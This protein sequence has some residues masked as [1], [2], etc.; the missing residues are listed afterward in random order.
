ME[1]R[2]SLGRFYAK[3]VRSAEVAGVAL[4]ESRYDAQVRM[5]EHWHDHAHFYLVLE[6]TCIDTY[7]RTEVECAPFTLMFHP[8]GAKHAADY[9]A[10][11]VRTFLMELRPHWLERVGVYAGGWDR[12]RDFRGGPACWVAG[13]LYNEFRDPDA[14]APLAIEGLVLELMAEVSR[15]GEGRVERGLPRWLSQAREHLA[16]EFTDSLSLTGLA[17]TVG[18]HPTHLAR[19]FRRRYHCT[20]GEYVRGL[21][22]EQARREL[23]TSDAPVAEIAAAA[24][25]SDQSH[26]C[27]I[28]KR[29]TALTPTEFRKKCSLR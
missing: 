17:Q 4:A 24:G 20:P 7:R 21:R 1:C 2:H 6:G 16:A 19:E 22:L 13:R 12:S 5:P 26:F 28:F 29:H 3:I 10:P 23:A 8:A 15:C 9:P 11:G 27:R 18:V 14:L 25:F